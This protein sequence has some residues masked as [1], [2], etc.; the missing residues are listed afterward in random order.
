MRS[1]FVFRV[2][3]EFLLEHESDGVEAEVLLVR[4]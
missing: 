2:R 3:L 1:Y 4:Q